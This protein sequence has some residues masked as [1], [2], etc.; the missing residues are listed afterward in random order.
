MLQFNA[1]VLITTNICNLK[2]RHC[3]PA[4]GPSRSE[5]FTYGS[6]K[7]MTAQQAEHYIKQIP[8]LK[9]I[10]QRIHFS[11]GESTLFA[12]EF[13]A[14]VALGKKYG[15]RVSV[16]TNCSWAKDQEKADNFIEDLARR[17]LTRIEISLS[18]FH[19]EFLDIN[20]PIRAIRACKKHGLEIILRPIVTKTASI[21]KTLQAIPPKDLEGTTIAVSKCMPMGRA[22]SEI[23]PDEF[24]YPEIHYGG[25]QKILNLTI[26]QD[27]SVYPC[28]AGSDITNALRLGNADRESLRDIIARAELDPLLVALT[29]QGPRYLAELLRETG[30]K[31][32]LKEKHV[33]ICHLCNDLFIDDEIAKQVRTA[34]ADRVGKG[35]K[36]FTLVSLPAHSII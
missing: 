15:L 19:Q 7:T 14:L 30:G 20:Y 29:E 24:V 11:G 9:N 33:N 26:R 1:V 17:G 25:C 3:Y 18:V 4:S 22:K 13:R 36:N 34:L 8:E 6:N 12:Q 10:N 28:C 32:F 23:P 27:G 2:C 31:D 5:A 21:A 35:L 16:T